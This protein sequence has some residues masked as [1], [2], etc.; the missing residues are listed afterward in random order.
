ML[1]IKKVKLTLNAKRTNKL[2]LNF[3]IPEDVNAN[4]KFNIITPDGKK[5]D[6]S[7]PNISITVLE[8]EQV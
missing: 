3:K 2:V 4:L 8:S 6:S 5:I 7:D 1:S